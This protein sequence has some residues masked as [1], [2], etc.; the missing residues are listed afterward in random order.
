MYVDFTPDQKELR[1]RIR[2]YFAGLMTDSTRERLSHSIG[3]PVYK[4]VI[5]QIGKDGWLGVGWPQEWGG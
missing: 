1:G 3:G 5:R 4:E 2:E